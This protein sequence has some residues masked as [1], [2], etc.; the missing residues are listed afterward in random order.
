MT[1]RT[2]VNSLQISSYIEYLCTAGEHDAM[3]PDHDKY[4]CLKQKTLGVI[5]CYFGEKIQQDIDDYLDAA[6]GATSKRN[7]RVR[8]TS[9]RGTND[10]IRKKLF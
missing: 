10:L 9:V 6:D 5:T 8:T 3:V 2:K 1:V 7:K 4:N